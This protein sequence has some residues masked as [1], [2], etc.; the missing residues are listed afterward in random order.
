MLRT[1]NKTIWLLAP[2]FGLFSFAAGC[3]N[4]KVKSNNLR[5]VD[6]ARHSSGYSGPTTI[7][8]NST[9]GIALEDELIF[10]C[11]GETLVWKAG[12]GVN[13]ITV[14]FPGSTGPFTQP[15]ES[16]G[17]HGDASSPTPVRE[18]AG[19]LPNTR[20]NAFKYQITVVTSGATINL[21]PHIIR[22][23]P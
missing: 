15:V 2:A 16:N 23:G 5:H 9:D 21:D 18:V 1:K 4:S 17:L 12:S 6:C 8:V 14:T 3:D 7:A 10:V 11:T 22:M 13:T 20:A 19:L